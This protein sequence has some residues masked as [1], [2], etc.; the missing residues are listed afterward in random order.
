MYA[1]LRPLGSAE[2]TMQLYDRI[3]PPVRRSASAV[4]RH[5][6]VVAGDERVRAAMVRSVASYGYAVTAVPSGLDALAELTH[7]DGGAP[8]YEVV[9][10]ARDLPDMTGR[11]LAD[12]VNKTFRMSA[13][14]IALS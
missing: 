13:T 12:T 3:I 5:A 1:A 9:V 7:A 11:K 2:V 10:A 8:L 6:L 4:V 14:V